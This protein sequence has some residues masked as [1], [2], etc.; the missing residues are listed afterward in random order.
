MPVRGSLEP[1]VPCLPL[2]SVGR[3]PD[4]APVELKYTIQ[5]THDKSPGFHED[6]ISSGRLINLIPLMGL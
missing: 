2:P 5:H 3:V 1:N 4:M 6:G